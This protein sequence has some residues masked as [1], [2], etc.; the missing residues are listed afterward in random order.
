MVSKASRE[1]KGKPLAFL[2][3]TT[4]MSSG[5]Q[6]NLGAPAYSY[7]FVAEALRPVLEKLGT[8]EWID[9][10]ESRLPFAAARAEADGFRPIHLAICPPQEAYLAPGIPNMLFPFWEFPD[11]P[12]RNF[13]LETRQNWSR[14]SDRADLILAACQFTADAFRRVG[15]TTPVAV[16]P[17]PIASEIFETPAW[18]PSASWSTICRHEIWQ[19][20]TV[21]P[22]KAISTV[23]NGI[24]PERTPGKRSLAS[25]AFRK[26]APRLDPVTVG[27]LCRIKQAVVGQSPAKLA[28]RGVRGLYK[29]TF[30]LALSDEAI[31]TISAMRVATFRKLGRSTTAIIDPLL[32]EAPL[33]LSGLVY[34][35][36][37]NVGDQRKNLGDLLSGFLL[38]FRDR[39]DVSL[40][41][42]LASRPHS[43][44]HEMAVLR[45]VYQ[46]LGIE[47]ACR[48]VVITDYLDEAQMQGLQRATTYYVNTSH[49]EGACLPLQQAL[50]AGRPAIAPGHS[51][52]ADYMSEDVGFVIGSS[53][54]PTHWPHDPDESITTERQRL[55]WPDL[56]EA[57]LKSAQVAEADH[58]RYRTLSHAARDRMQ[59]QS[60]IE[61]A[62]EAM[63]AALTELLDF[64]KAAG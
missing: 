44:H 41:L 64:R 12:N 21:R 49:A 11:I 20:S 52:M 46:R 2:V 35:S 55:H 48:V 22:F 42:K 56:F 47:H 57:F 9:R 58:A 50:A 31:D 13:G 27:R 28:Y 61:V 62:T 14:I 3:S 37:A 1:G 51:A 23:S 33:E 45:G 63:K 60:S 34:T 19:G 25:R 30:Q 38:A 7:Y 6:R 29:R 17:V 18:K 32:P 43:E 8:W 5:I 59:R 36:F 54:E 39:S 16:V 15:N 10:P 40:V 53:A 26:V 4:S 24:E